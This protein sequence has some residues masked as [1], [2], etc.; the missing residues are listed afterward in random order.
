MAL[1]ASPILGTVHNI[2]S[3]ERQDKDFRHDS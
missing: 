2:R 1:L 3:I